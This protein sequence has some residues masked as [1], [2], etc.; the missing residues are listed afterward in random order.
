LLLVWTEFLICALL[1]LFFGAKLARYGDIIAEKTGLGGIWVGLLLLAAV[2]SLPEIIT[3]VS[4]ITLV[5]GREGVNLALGNIFGSNALNLLIIAIMDIIYRSG[6]LLSVVGKGHSFSA[7]LGILL[8]AFAGVSII[9][10]TDVWN[11]AIGWVGIYSVVLVLLYLW[12]SRRIFSSERERE[13]ENPVLKYQ[14]LSSWR[15]YLGFAIVALAIIGAGTWLAFIGD[16]IATGT[17]WDATFVGSL[18]LAVTTSLPELAVCIAALRIGAMDMAIADVLGSNMFN[19]GIGIFCYDI[20]SRGSSIFS[21]ASHDHI[22]TAVIAILM[23]FIVIAGLV[24]RPG[25][26]TPL[27]ISWHSLALIVIYLG[28]AYALF[29]APWR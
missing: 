12:G 29:T 7:G 8:I 18:F 17:G 28:G 3:G 11:G 10:S 16:E 19:I 14:K 15:S 26:I 4:A 21:A 13:V 6:P 24:S 25:R 5:G 23:T 27:R 2:T 20:F 1:I 9:L 22:F